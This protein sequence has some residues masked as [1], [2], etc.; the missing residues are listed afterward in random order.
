MSSSYISEQTG[1]L[2]IF[3]NKNYSKTELAEGHR[4]V[5]ESFNKN[6]LHLKS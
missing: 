2:N 3:L 5:A 4:F 1:P 6:K